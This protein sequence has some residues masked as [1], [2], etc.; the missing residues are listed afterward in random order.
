MWSVS[1]WQVQFAKSGEAVGAP[2]VR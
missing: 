2:V 1:P